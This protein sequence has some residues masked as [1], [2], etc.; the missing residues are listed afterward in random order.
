MNRTDLEDEKRIV[1]Q[2]TQNRYQIKKLIGTPKEK[3]KRKGVSFPADWLDH[4]FQKIWLTETGDADADADTDTDVIRCLDREL[5]RK[6][7]SYKYQDKQ[8]ISGSADADADLNLAKVKEMLSTSELLCFYC[9]C[10][11]YVF[12]EI[13]R[14]DRQWTLD[15]IDNNKGHVVDN[16]VISC[17]ACNLKRRCTR[18]RDF[19]FTKQLK[20][21]K[22]DAMG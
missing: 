18:H 19:L 1:I 2:G 8:K 22:D 6:I 11:V 14:E 15:R 20:V 21:I 3:E 9:R 10:E 13:A 5:E 4:T 12:Y 17:L 7:A 16:V